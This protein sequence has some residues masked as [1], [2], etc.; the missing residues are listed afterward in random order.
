MNEEVGQ[1]VSETSSCLL[2]SE[3]QQRLT[4]QRLKKEKSDHSLNLPDELTPKSKEEQGERNQQKPK[5]KAWAVRRKSMPRW[6]SRK[7]PPLLQKSSSLTEPGKVSDLCNEEEVENKEEKAEGGGEE[8]VGREEK[9]GESTPKLRSWARLR[10]EVASSQTTEEARGQP[11]PKLRSWAR[12]RGAS[13]PA[14]SLRHLEARYKTMEREQK[15]EQAQKE[16]KQK[17]NKKEKDGSLSNDNHLSENADSPQTHHHNNVNSPHRTDNVTTTHQDNNVYLPE[18]EKNKEGKTKERTADNQK[19]RVEGKGKLEWGNVSHLLFSHNHPR[20]RRSHSD[21]PKSNH[22]ASLITSYQTSPPSFI[23]SAG[24]TSH[25]VQSNNLPLSPV[26][27]S[28]S[29]PSPLPPDLPHLHNSTHEKP[30][31]AQ[32]R[33][34]KK[35]LEEKKKKQKFSSLTKKI[36]EENEVM[37][38]ESLDKFQ[39]ENQSTSPQNNPSQ[40][41]SPPNITQT[42]SNHFAAPP[43]EE[44][45]TASELPLLTP[46]SLPLPPLSFVPSSPSFHSQ[47]NL[48]CGNCRRRLGEGVWYKCMQCSDYNLCAS[49]LNHQQTIWFHDDNHFFEHINDDEEV[50][51][52]ET[53]QHNSDAPQTPPESHQ[54]TNQTIKSNNN[55]YKTTS[56]QSTPH[57]ST[58]QPRDS[59][60]GGYFIAA[61]AII[62]GIALLLAG[63]MDWG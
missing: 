13:P 47:E 42:D 44:S 55:T 3:P 49:C 34:W 18:K 31:H 41:N 8:G 19:E 43:N 7:A 54:H 5:L 60:F 10:S 23:T 20:R 16:K 35:K 59:S 57:Y 61:A 38:W 33:S 36:L 30:I 51:T 46:S 63:A 26:S 62:G 45:K 15:Q 53:D 9:G 56:S 24:I 21:R 14:Y 12:L 37:L 11:P 39:D 6:V 50:L 32:I 1:K 29:S 17:E 58:T 40:H 28:L 48:E 25:C 27:P 2:P 4:E 52:E 22:C